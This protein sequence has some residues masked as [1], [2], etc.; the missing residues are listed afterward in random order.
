MRM[1]RARSRLDSAIESM[2]GQSR[3]A[4]PGAMSASGMSTSAGDVVS[5]SEPRGRSPRNVAVSKC[6]ASAGLWMTIGLAV[7]GRRTPAGLT[8]R[9]MSELTSVDFPAPVEPPT[10]MRKGA[11]ARLIR[12]RMKSPI[13]ELRDPSSRRPSAASS[14]CRVNRVSEIFFAISLSAP[15]T[16]GVTAFP[17]SVIT[18]P[19]STFSQ[20]STTRHAVTGFNC[21]RTA[22]LRREFENPGPA[23]KTVASRLSRGAYERSERPSEPSVTDSRGRVVRSVGKTQTSLSAAEVDELVALYEQGMTLARL[24]E[25]FGVYHRTVAAHLVRRSVPMRVR[26]LAEEHTCE[27]VRL[28]EGGM[29]LMEVGLHFGVSQGQ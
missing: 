4:V 6:F 29:T 5:G 21:L 9:P 8:V 25:R 11:G 3:T 23:L 13:S 18:H 19:L 27:A 14:V 1:R 10:A 12:G 26:G 22:H 16:G 7:V 2:S 28:Y 15:P 17:L 20:L 24:G